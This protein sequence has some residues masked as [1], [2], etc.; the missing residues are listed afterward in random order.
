MGNDRFKYLLEKF[1]LGAVHHCDGLISDRKIIFSLVS[2][3][4]A[5]SMKI[6]QTGS[7]FS[8]S[9]IHYH[10]EVDKVIKKLTTGALKILD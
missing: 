1:K 2:K 10:S 3:Y 9:T 8:S 4:L 5:T 7:V 6:F